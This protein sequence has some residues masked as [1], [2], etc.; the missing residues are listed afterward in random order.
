MLIQ[1]HIK[2]LQ[3]KLDKAQELL[4]SFENNFK[5]EIAED[6]EQTKN[7]LKEQINTNNQEEMRE[8]LN[9]VKERIESEERALNERIE[10]NLQQELRT[11]KEQLQSFNAQKL[12]NIIQERSDEILELLKPYLRNT[13]EWLLE[14]EE[15]R[16]LLT[17]TIQEATQD[18]IANLDISASI[19]YEKIP[20][21]TQEITQQVQANLRS[22][23]L[24][25]V[26]NTTQGFLTKSNEVIENAVLNKSQEIYNKILSSHTFLTQLYQSKLRVL[27]ADIFNSQYFISEKI[28]EKSLAFS[29]S[30]IQKQEKPPI[31]KQ[32]ILVSK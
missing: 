28:R 6:L 21:D 31:K 24:E 9:S 7:T 10:Q 32:N 11:S 12:G 1:E 26:E 25:S 20:L 2:E 27:S 18:K 14:K 16:E 15:F 30:Q 4:N 23:I 13:P 22:D 17:Q 29:K 5:Q 3:Q 8:L 19:D